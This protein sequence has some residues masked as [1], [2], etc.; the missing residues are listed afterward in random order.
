MRRLTV[1]A[2]LCALAAG[3]ASV[4]SQPGSDNSQD[5]A[6]STGP[7]KIDPT[8]S[9]TLMNLADHVDQEKVDLTGVQAGMP[10]YD[11]LGL[12][13]PIGYNLRNRYLNIGVPIAEGFARDLDPDFRNQLINM[14][15]WSHGGETRSAALLILA[16]QQ[17]L[18]D[19]QILNEALVFLDPAVRFGALGALQVF[20]HP[21]MAM[22]LLAAASDRDPFPVLRVYAAA[23]SARLGDPAGLQ[24]L[25]NFLDDPS[26][27]IRAMAA[28][29]LGEN[30]TPADYDLLVSRI[31][32]ETLNDF[33]VAELCVAA[34][35]LYPQK[36][37]AVKQAA[38]NADVLN[39]PTQALPPADSGNI[40]DG[41]GTAYQLEPLVIR[42][43]RTH[44]TG[45]MPIDPQIN[46]NLLR[47]LQK[48]GERPN[49]DQAA[50][51]NVQQLSQL[52]TVDGYNLQIRYN[53]LGFLLTEGLAGTTDFELLTAL[54]H[55][56]SSAK[57]V[58]IRAAA[59]V[60]LAY[61][62]DPQYLPI[63]QQGLNSNNNITVRFGAL[64][65]LLIMGDPGT[66]LQISNAAH[67]D[68]SP[69]IQLYAA[70]GMWKMGDIF[71]QQILQHNYQAQDW[72][73][74]AMAAHYLGE[75]GSGYEYRELLQQLQ[76]ESNPQVQA[77]LC[78]ALM[79]LQKFKDD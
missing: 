41:A 13:S 49:A 55:T 57:N 32:R 8:I 69:A 16:R 25:R 71:G 29:Y 39:K 21:E 60:A 9:N 56:A 40:P 54:Q 5:V 15:R 73:T 78:S 47:L 23:G 24:R 3:C 43:P 34:L 42:A 53:Q 79:R 1:L 74:R 6:S 68:P 72:F 35:K 64:E 44:I 51:A 26:W 19:T 7:V 22:P 17:N 33:N 36:L 50:D 59:M 67:S 75:L 76:Q 62:K 12:G 58:Q 63:F 18:A 2:A 20:G 65:S 14:A 46:S 48:M 31:G 27:L 38:A 45:D 28:R 10:V 4:P 30:G 61:T 11:I 37:A 52:S 77:E 70:A 66:Q